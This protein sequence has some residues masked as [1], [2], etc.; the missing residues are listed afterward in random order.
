MGRQHRRATSRRHHRDHRAIL[1]Q[2][3]S[4][5]RTPYF[6][7]CTPM[8]DHTSSKADDLAGPHQSRQAVSKQAS[9]QH[10][11]R[12]YHQ[13]QSRNDPRAE[14]SVLSQTLHRR[15][16]KSLRA[17]PPLRHLIPLRHSSPPGDGSRGLCLLALP[18]AAGACW[19]AG[20][21]CSLAGFEVL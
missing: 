8:Q 15:Y 10:K 20:C 12:T 14:S 18:G 5:H 6:R 7:K 13:S 11:Q 19:R 1:A 16:R 9:S 17:P 3:S 2:S 4:G 21:C